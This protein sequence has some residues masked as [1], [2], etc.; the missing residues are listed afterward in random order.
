MSTYNL[1][2]R[3]GLYALPARGF[4]VL[5]HDRTSVSSH[6]ESDDIC[7]D[8]YVYARSTGELYSSQGRRS[9]GSYAQ[10]TLAYTK[11]DETKRTARGP[12]LIAKDCLLYYDH[13]KGFSP[14]RC[15][16]FNRGSVVTNQH[17]RGYQTHFSPRRM[18]VIYFSQLYFLP[19]AP[20][21]DAEQGGKT[22]MEAST[23]QTAT[24]S[25]SPRTDKYIIW[26]SDRLN[27]KPYEARLFSLVPEDSVYTS[28]SRRL[29]VMFWA[30]T[31]TEEQVQSLED[32]SVCAGLYLPMP[33][34][35]LISWGLPGRDY[36]S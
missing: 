12:N 31:L 29:G 18:G 20:N 25:T 6:V 32:P 1:S 4:V 8:I 17:M 33:A 21:M 23:T 27:T 24:G 7:M 16:S 35:S 14:I 15:H 26:P 34:S 2:A 11:C 5:S 22:E 30:V 19:S 3:D 10:S 36:Q 9:W 28:S 13:P